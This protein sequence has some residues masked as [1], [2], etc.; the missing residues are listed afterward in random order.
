MW[1]RFYDMCSGGNRKEQFDNCYIEAAIEEAK[2][3]FFNRFGHNPNRVTCTCCGEDYS[4]NEDADLAQATA[5]ERGCKWAYFKGENQVPE[6]EGWIR[7]KGLADGV[8]GR[9]IEQADETRSYRDY[10]PLDQ[11]VKR[12]DVLVIYAKD[13]K[14]EER[15]GNI[16]QQGYV[17]ID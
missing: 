11:Y 5:Y 15:Q 10:I 17:W 4:I 13:I 14:D 9:Y 6:S 12:S 1:T 16:P 8:V 3:I 7:G 2:V